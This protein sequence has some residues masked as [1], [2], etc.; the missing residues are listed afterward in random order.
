MPIKRLFLATLLLSLLCCGAHG[1]SAVAT[2]SNNG[3]KPVS[4]IEAKLVWET[5]FPIADFGVDGIENFTI[6]TAREITCPAENFPLDKCMLIAL[7]GKD[8]KKHGNMLIMITTGRRME[9]NSEGREVTI[10]SPEF[11]MM[12]VFKPNNPKSG[13]K[14]NGVDRLL[15]IVAARAT[16]TEEVWY[17]DH[18]HYW[19]DNGFLTRMKHQ[20]GEKPFHLMWTEEALASASIMGLTPGEVRVLQTLNEDGKK[21]RQKIA[22]NAAKTKSVATNKP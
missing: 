2:T 6:R 17:R 5:N 18:L 20:Q 4:E 1:Q 11:W 8:Q 22:Q 13:W 12:Q 10:N 7:D 14:G 15:P 19:M 9:K 3:T 21:L 16:D